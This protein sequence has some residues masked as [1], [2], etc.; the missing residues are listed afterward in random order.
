M[1][2]VIALALKDLRLLLR[3]K[4]GAFFTF[5]W[6]LMSAVVFGSVFAGGGGGRALPI[7]VVDED[8]SEASR[9]VVKALEDGD[10][11]EVVPAAT[12]AEAEDLVRRGKRPV[13][14][15]F[16]AG[17]GAA[18][19]D[20]RGAPPRVDLGAD[21]TRKAEA[22]TAAGILTAVAT[23]LRFPSGGSAFRPVEVATIDVAARRE[24]PPNSYSFTFPQGIAW[25][26][27][28][29]CAAFALSLVTE[30]TRGTLVRLATAPIPAR[31]VLLGKALACLATA[32]LV[33]A[34]L[35]AFGAALFGVRVRSF[36]FLALAIVSAGTCF[37]GLQTLVGT[38]GKTEASASGLSWALLLAM[39]MF[40]GAMVPLFFMPPWMLAA[41]AWSPIRWT[42]YALEAGI[43]RDVGVSDVLGPCAILVGVGV[44]SFLAGTRL[45][46]VA[47]R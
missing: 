1:T 10:A 14:A 35:I 32:C 24:G 42:I 39:A 8:R 9:A 34:V 41:S 19:K 5:V 36:G 18:A 38:I 33:C 46:R 6:P 11:V 16:P 15:V 27:I 4:G 37:A 29:A 31:T 7:V 23:R 2:P 28:G 17:Y 40:G 30:R 12:R 20:F 13:Y 25:G 45:L 21:P 22:A 3:D 47:D 26:L 43:W 44:A